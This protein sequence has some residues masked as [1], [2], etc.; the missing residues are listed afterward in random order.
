[1]RDLFAFTGMDMPGRQELTVGAVLLNGQVLADEDALLA[2]L[3][4][5]VAQAPFRHMTT[6]GGFVMS[7]AMTSCGA[8]GWVTDRSGYR[9]EPCDPQSSL[10]WP[11]MPAL[12]GRLA[13]EA[14][15]QAGFPGFVPDTC[16]INRYEP[17]ARMSLHQDK[18]EG[19]FG[20]PIV[21]VSL[22]LS[23]TFQFGGLQRSDKP[24]KISLH[25]GDVVVWGGP[26]RLAYHG[27][28]ALRDGEHPRLGR[29]RINL[30]FRRAL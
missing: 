20:N 30:T 26:A 15:A 9:Y 28:L 8:V 18:D 10:P 7:V 17:G 3:D 24:Q 19:D 12:F 23:A 29:K 22:G 5:I 6:P 4:A 27:V 25:H 2:A 13:S 14:A 11:A 1:M 21:S 16:L